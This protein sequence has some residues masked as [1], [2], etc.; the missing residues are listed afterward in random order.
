MDWQF[1]V[2]LAFAALFGLLPFWVKEMPL[3]LTLAGIAAAV[4]FG[5][6]GLPWIDARVQP[7]YGLVLIALV[8]GTV[9]T[10]TLIVQSIVDFPE[11]KISAFSNNVEYPEGSIVSGIKFHPQFTEAAILLKNDSTKDFDELTLVFQ[12]D[13]P[14]AAIGQKTNISNVSFEE[15]NGFDAR[16]MIADATGKRT[17]VPDVVLLATDAGY[18]MR[19]PKFVGQS[20]MQITIALSDVVQ[21]QHPEW[22]ALPPEEQVKKKRTCGS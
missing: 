20:S 18:R 9:A 11:P 8:S 2:G 6:W 12:F 21:E 5:A 7:L 19:C 10:L 1:K 13:E 14:I 16:V 22:K 17:A 3:P 15:K 4:M